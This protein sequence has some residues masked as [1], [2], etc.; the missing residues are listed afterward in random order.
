VQSLLLGG[1]FALGPD[2]TFQYADQGEPRRVAE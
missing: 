2:Q 1:A